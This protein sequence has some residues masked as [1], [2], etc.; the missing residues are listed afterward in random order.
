VSTWTLRTLAPL[1][2][3]RSVATDELSVYS[4]LNDF[5]RPEL[6]DGDNKWACDACTKR[7]PDTEKGDSEREESEEKASP[8]DSA[9]NSESNLR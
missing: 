5:S 1:A 4:C 6:L 9:S 7:M 8:K 2:S 3:K